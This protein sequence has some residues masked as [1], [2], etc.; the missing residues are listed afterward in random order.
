MKNMNILKQKKKLDTMQQG[1][2]EG[3]LQVAEQ[4]ISKEGGTYGFEVLWERNRSDLSVED[5]V[6]N[7]KFIELFTASELEMCRKS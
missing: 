5:F 3:G 1:C 6:L 4:L 2:R 7:L